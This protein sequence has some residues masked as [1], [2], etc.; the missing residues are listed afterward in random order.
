MMRASAAAIAALVLLA[1]CQPSAA[2]P[3]GGR[4][5]FPV[6][7][8]AV[9]IDD[10]EGAGLYFTA[11]AGSGR[12]RM[13]EYDLRTAE[14][15]IRLDRPESDATFLFDVE[16]DRMLWGHSDGE[17]RVLEIQ[18]GEGVMRELMRNATGGIFA[19]LSEDVVLASV[20]GRGGS[21]DLIVHDLG[22][23]GTSRVAS[24]LSQKWFD[25][26]GGYAVYTR[27]GTDGDDVVLLD[28]LEEGS[29][30]ISGSGQRV[31]G[32]Y[33]APV[34]AEGGFAAWSQKD[35]GDI[36]GPFEIVVWDIEGATGWTAVEAEGLSR[37]LLAFDG[38]RL[39][40]VR[41][42]RGRD[43]SDLAGDLVLADLGGNETVLSPAG[44]IKGSVRIDCG[45]VAWLEGDLL[46]GTLYV[47]TQEAYPEPAV[48]SYCEDGMDD[49]DGR[50]VTSWW[51]PLLAVIA[52]VPIA[53]SIV[54]WWRRGQGDG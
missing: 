40:Y 29:H 44:G 36:D 39:V 5:A 50:G 12:T 21:F 45:T 22:T 31:G 54:R 33:G 23:G 17:D 7:R 18:E 16:G 8:C 14:G 37:I 4:R 13:I 38:E 25:A 9:L 34:L 51:W 3:A 42:D 15:H 26:W 43:A 53:W 19:M 30:V 35:A 41:Y 46:N 27:S 32:S 49:E 47:S 10:L 2:D 1:L 6:A 52:A 28:L 24:D 48:M 11:H 20:S